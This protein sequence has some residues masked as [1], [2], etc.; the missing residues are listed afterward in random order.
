MTNSSLITESRLLKLDHTRSPTNYRWHPKYS[1][2][3]KINSPTK[4]DVSTSYAK[5]I[6]IINCGKHFNHGQ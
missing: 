1:K 4:Y 5:P 6:K 2:N 3:Y